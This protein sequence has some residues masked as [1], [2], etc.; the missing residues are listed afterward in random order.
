M[1]SLIQLFCALFAP[2]LN[3]IPGVIAER[4]HVFCLRHRMTRKEQVYF[5]QNYAKLISDGFKINEALTILKTEYLET[6]GK[7]C[8]EVKFCTEALR[9]M[10]DEGA[11]SVSDAMSNWFFPVFT[12]VIS[13]STTSK[14][15]S[16]ALEDLLENFN[17]WEAVRKELLSI[18]KTPVLLTVGSLFA[19]TMI[20]MYGLE[21]VGGDKFEKNLTDLSAF[22]HAYGV[23][24]EQNI[25]LVLLVMLFL[26]LVYFYALFNVNSDF[27]RVLDSKIP[28]FGLYQAFQAANFYTIMAILVSPSGGNLKLK[29]ALE[30]FENNND[31]TSDYLATHIAEMFRRAEIDG[32]SNLEQ[33]NTGLLPLKMKIR[34]GIA[35]KTKGG[36]TMVTTFQSIS[37]N[38]AEDYKDQIKHRMRNLSQSAMFFS[39]VLVFFSVLA[40][41]DVA[42]SR[43]DS[44]ML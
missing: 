36:L 22:F 5:L 27:R 14:N 2:I 10:G 31:L 43:L 32:L 8:S 42:F 40:M 4:L 9:Q 17:R 41:L 30:E 13:V 16:Q 19:T 26:T 38:L 37:Q 12:Q 25:K 39:V 3:L 35:G 18:L 7:D 28:G 21:L 20:S 24:A 15:T 11:L 29:E 33:L 23:W 6:L 34:L 1:E 44:T